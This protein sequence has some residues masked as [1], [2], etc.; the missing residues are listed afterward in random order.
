MSYAVEKA[1]CPLVL[2]LHGLTQPS[3][4]G[5]NFSGAALWLIYK[6]YA[7]RLLKNTSNI[8]C[9]S[10]DTMKRVEAIFPN[11]LEKCTVIPNGI[12]AAV[13]MQRSGQ[14][15]ES[16]RDKLGL[17]NALTFIYAGRVTQSKGIDILA[18]SAA[19]LMNKGEN[20]ALLIVGTGPELA[21]MRE[22]YSQF[23]EIR[24]LGFKEDV[25]SYYKAADVAVLASDREGMSTFLL[26]AM[27]YGL[28]ILTTDV[29][30]VKELVDVGS[31]CRIISNAGVQE[32]TTG[33][34]YFLNLDSSQLKE[35]GMINAD[36]ARE[37]FSWSSLV[38]RTLRVYQEA[39]DSFNK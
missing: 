2:T 28:P 35:W 21:R 17:G 16:M 31:K 32:I 14:S 29:G 22:K 26:E 5:K 6:S 37:H 33:L 19:N 15:R 10:S 24:F 36:L 38:D 3:E 11:M 18:S 34:L 9:V 20:V 1:S 8:I 23:T 12:E 30:G 7:P 39:I 13:E 4:I 27:Y 25:G